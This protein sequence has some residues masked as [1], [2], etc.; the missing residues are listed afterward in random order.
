[1]PTSEYL[2]GRAR[3]SW[4]LVLVP[5]QHGGTSTAQRAVMD[6]LC[7]APKEAMRYFEVCHSATAGLLDDAGTELWEMM[8]ILARVRKT[9]CFTRTAVMRPARS[10]MLVL[11]TSR[12]MH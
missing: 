2:R 5:H 6:S 11:S 1:M 4:T 3:G 9:V 10:V 8:G 12:L 7:P